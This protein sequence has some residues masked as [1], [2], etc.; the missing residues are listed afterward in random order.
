MNQLNQVPAYVWRCKDLFCNF[1]VKLLKGKG[2]IKRNHH[3]ADKS[4]LTRR[5]FLRY[6]QIMFTD[7]LQGGKT[8]SFPGRKYLE[9]RMREMKNSHFIAARR[10]GAYL[11]VDILL[12]N[13]KHYECVLT[14]KFYGAFKHTVVKLSQD[15]RGMIV[16]R[17]N[18]GYKYC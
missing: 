3:C 9:L 2:N 17:V 11:D 12:S 14:R 13:R 15:L 8:F 18:E 4:E 1:D 10:A 16:T 7:F 5:I 6:L